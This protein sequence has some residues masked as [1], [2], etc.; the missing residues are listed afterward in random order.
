MGKQEVLKLVEVAEI[1][2][3]PVS[4]LQK[5]IREGKLKATKNGREY[6]CDKTRIK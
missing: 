5:H 2:G 1:V 4:T 3:V 6:F